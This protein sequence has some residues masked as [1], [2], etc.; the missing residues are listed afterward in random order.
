MPQSPQ[1]RIAVHANALYGF[2]DAERRRAAS[3]DAYIGDARHPV[4][5]KSDP[6]SR[7]VLRWIGRL[8]QS[9]TP[10]DLV[11]AVEWT[12]LP[13]SYKKAL[14]NKC[15]IFSPHFTDG[16]ID[17]EDL[18]R[19]T[20]GH[21][22][23]EQPDK[24]QFVH[25]LFEDGRHPGMKKTKAIVDRPAPRAVSGFRT[26][27]MATKAPLLIAGFPLV[28]FQACHLAGPFV[29]EKFIDYL[30]DDSGSWTEGMT[31]VGI[32]AAL[33]LIK[34]ILFQKHFHMCMKVGLTT[35]G[36]LMAQLF[37]KVVAMS[38][39]A[40]VHPSNGAGTIINFMTAEINKVNVACGFVHYI[41]TS[42][43]Q[44]FIAMGLLYLLVG[45]I[46]FAAVALGAL[47]VPFQAAVLRRQYRVIDELA[48]ASDKRVATV[49]EVFAAISVVKVMGWEMKFLRHVSEQRQE[50]LLSLVKMKACRIANA[51]FSRASPMLVMASVF[52][53]YHVT[54]HTLTARVIFPVMALLDI[55][56]MQFTIIP[57]AFNS[58][59]TSY[60]SLEE[61][62]RFLE[63]DDHV[64]PVQPLPDAAPGDTTAT[65][66]IISEANF[67]VYQALPIGEDGDAHD[68]FDEAALGNNQQASMHHDGL[69]EERHLSIAERVVWNI[70]NWTSAGKPKRAGD[71]G[72]AKSVNDSTASGLYDTI[73][74]GSEH[75]DLLFD[76]E[77]TKN[78]EEAE[79]FHVVPK[80]LLRDITLRVNA[81]ELTIV[82]GQTGAGKSMLLE[83]ILGELHVTTGSISAVTDVAYVQ[84]E[85]WI[86][87]TTLKD[88]ITFCHPFD[89]EQ[90]A[91][92]VK[93]CH[94]E[95]D[96][97]QFCHGSD[98]E[99]GQRGVS[100]SGGQRARIAL[101]R[102]VYARPELYL[103]DDPLSAVDPHV[104]KAVL[105]DCILGAL[106]HKTRILVTHHTHVLPHADRVVVMADGRI[107]F[108]GTYSEYE[109]TT[110]HH[111][112][113]N[114]RQ[115]A[116]SEAQTAHLAVDDDE[117]DQDRVCLMM[118]PV[119]RGN[120]DSPDL[121][122]RLRREDISSSSSSDSE[123]DGMPEP[124][125]AAPHEECHLNTQEERAEGSVPWAIYV[126]YFRMCGGWGRVALVIVVYVVT[127]MIKAA[128]PVW[129]SLWAD[130]SIPH[131]TADDYFYVYVGLAAAGTLTAAARGTTVYDA[132]LRA[133]KLMHCTLLQSTVRATQGFHDSTPFGRIVN[134]FSRD[135]DTCDNE[136]PSSFAETLESVCDIFSACAIMIA[137]QLWSVVVIVPS[138]VLYMM[139]MTFFTAAAREL[140][141]SDLLNASP[142]TE[143]MSGC[144]MDGGKTIRASRTVPELL[145]I[146][147]SVVDA[148]YTSSYLTLV[149]NRWL[150]LRLELLASVVVVA[151]AL[152]AV[153]T[154]Q[155]G[156]NPQGVAVISLGLTLAMSI[157][158]SLNWL[159]R[160]AS[161]L[162]A[163]M[164]CVQ[165]VMHYGSEI[166]TDDFTQYSATKKNPLPDVPLA[167]HLSPVTVRS[168][169]GADAPSNSHG[170]GACD[171]AEQPGSVPPLSLECRG[172][173][174]QYRRDF[175][176]VLK[177]V[178]FA[179]G[180]GETVGI[181]G[182]TGSGK[183]TT[184]AAF[185]RI[186]DIA[187]GDLFIGGQPIR[188]FSLEHL[189]SLFAVIPQE[190]VLF[191]AACLRENLDPFH[192]HSDQ[193]VA[194]AIALV[195]MADRVGH[196]GGI[197][198][199]VTEG[200]HN[201]SVGQRQLL[202]LARAL[203]KKGASFVLMDEAT[204]N[205]DPATDKIIQ[206]VIRS[207]FRGKTV[208]MIA[209][210][211]HTVLGCDK[212][213]CMDSG[214]AKEVGPPHELIRREGGL[215]RAMVAAHGR[216]HVSRLLHVIEDGA[217][218]RR[219][220]RV[221]GDSVS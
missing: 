194:E 166:P 215:L 57:M 149:S 104:G 44:L 202:C 39:K 198:C 68:G 33:Y 199:A 213:V 147:V 76:S 105:E 169:A 59:V 208:I 14:K 35:R 42:P 97:A 47:T 24:L 1:D 183:S 125:G 15:A 162:E 153:V 99:I 31:L 16:I 197:N 77:S 6:E 187:D 12:R 144:A 170:P 9:K 27:Y 126:K 72:I 75:G 214:V 181:I 191:S 100:L 122:P 37:H 111:H 152:A 50:E 185:L 20:S 13:S 54:G 79:F 211:L 131:W 151:I 98:A 49:N 55:I 62:G 56:R 7:G 118:P 137:A 60:I 218:R 120:N 167:P 217:A 129:L 188:S 82:V 173:T 94:L 80:V 61:I 64:S 165:R 175:P 109:A 143:M 85:P 210:R 46:G 117:D 90:F 74:D 204:A 40:R 180:A 10:Y 92:T 156:G 78:D 67:A 2:F 83:A 123:S 186:F 193:Q 130:K 91:A 86:V 145:R 157:T 174:L 41:W 139:L 206:R 88:N 23:I 182:R 112:R 128:A 134:R 158:T 5:Y 133:G 52:V 70:R 71:S 192:H 171:A 32:F 73:D 45:W 132:G 163:N 178:S 28:F 51:F 38:H 108:D 189:R 121:S 11:V 22:T 146:A 48:E 179:I 101:A 17:G 65:A 93:C 200:G 19:A 219:N 4:R 176:L 119:Q 150:G 29:L 140:K 221:V 168:G 115:Q 212:I 127:E 96:I 103:L 207:A 3:W 142:V 87:N 69:R 164:N 95:A 58:L 25:M 34:P 107:S 138:G 36:A 136:I 84:Q 161:G 8:A 201:F 216:S 124:D 141:R 148:R 135:M 159:I 26:L 209:H 30:S 220:E 203:L 114:E 89:E 196:D 177:G 102:A 154:K 195:G 63:S 43:L 160:R 53:L 18:F 106:R 81:G 110:H 116:Q 172:V 113:H 184:L 205:V 21:A 66:V 190:P 155:E